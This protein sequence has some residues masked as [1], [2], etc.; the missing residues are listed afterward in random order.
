MKVIDGLLVRIRTLG[1]VVSEGT[2]KNEG[3]YIPLSL[4]MN[5]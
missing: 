1:Q 5:W 3:S 4:L 2:I